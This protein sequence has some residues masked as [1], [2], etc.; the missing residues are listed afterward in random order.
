MFPSD[1]KTCSKCGEIKSLSAFYNRT[2]KCKECTKQGVR[3]NRLNNV[4]YYRNYDKIRNSS[5]VRINKNSEYT[6]YYRL[7]FPE[8]YKAHTSVN[9]ALRD[10]RLV[11]YSNCECCGDSK[12]IHA[13]HSSYSEEMHLIV[14]WL[15]AICHSK[16]HRDFDNLL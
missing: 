14:T 15:C 9:N 5:Q 6:K 12:D 16:L 1:V 4:E 7:E 13:H 11:S 8:K 10:K 3:L 2:N